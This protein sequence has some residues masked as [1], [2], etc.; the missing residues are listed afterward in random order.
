MSA[1]LAQRGVVHSSAPH[2]QGRLLSATASAS[3][4]QP[5]SRVDRHD[6]A[7]VAALLDEFREFQGSVRD[8]VRQSEIPRSTFL[9]W[10]ARQEALDEEP[11]LVAFFSSSAGL[12]LLHRLVMATHLCLR[13]SGAAGE[14]AVSQWLRLTR[15][16]VFVA[17]SAASH[18]LLA[19]Q[20]DESL[21]EFEQVHDARAKAQL[22]SPRPVHVGLD[23]MFRS[24]PILTVLDVPSGYVLEQVHATHRDEATW[25]RTLQDVQVRLPVTVVQGVGDEAKGLVNALEK[26]LG[27]PHHTDVF[28][29]QLDV[30]RATAAALRAQTTEAR[31]QLQKVEHQSDEHFPPELM[32]A[33][34]QA[35]EAEM[36]A[37]QMKKAVKKLSEA[38]HPI[39]VKTGEAREPEKVEQEL[40]EAVATMK[41][42]A[43]SAK[44]R[45]RAHEAIAKAERL[46][47][48][49][50]TTVAWWQQQ[51]VVWV[52]AAKLPE[53]VGELVLTVLLPAL[54]V[55]QCAERASGARQRETL[56]QRAAEWVGELRTPGHLWW[57]LSEAQR[58]EAQALGRQCAAAFLRSS[59]S[60]EGQQGWVSLHSQGWHGLPPER[61]VSLRVLRNHLLKDGEERS[62][63]E[64]L[65]GMASGDVF[66]WLLDRVELPS[67]PSAGKKG[68]R[69]PR[70]LLN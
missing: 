50:A 63:Y 49:M 38:M 59:S 54:Y 30:T 47:E 61:L 62:A 44:L 70:S 13:F 18:H 58:Q 64:R 29:P 9:H 4:A 25:T 5:R 60:V 23:E 8:F 11:E 55:E 24:G 15:L 65:F 34:G 37:G 33:R 31:E 45:P 35:Q 3:P 41:A 66:E 28:H 52:M 67:W 46:I 1:L 19:Q 69:G 27:V 53:G 68:S 43:E 20:I 26:G 51:V 12:A 10:L 39:D 32:Y 17:S 7:H 56:R 22:P 42:I 14:R 48:K 57:T 21:A 36:M 16:D 6:R 2:P 40:R